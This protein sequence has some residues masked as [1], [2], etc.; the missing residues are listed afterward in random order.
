MPVTL[1]SIK[2]LYA[3]LALEPDLS[4][5]GVAYPGSSCKEKGMEIVLK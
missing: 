2:E 5:D 4:S 3:A 1:R